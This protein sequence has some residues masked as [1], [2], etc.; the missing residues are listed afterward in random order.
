MSHSFVFKT[1]FA[2]GFFPLFTVDQEYGLGSWNDFLVLKLYSKKNLRGQ[3][4]PHEDGAMRRI[5]R[6]ILGP[7]REFPLVHDPA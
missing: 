3:I 1:L 5:H 7:H 6:A 2:I 4:D